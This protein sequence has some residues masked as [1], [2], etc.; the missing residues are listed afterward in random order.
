MGCH[1]SRL[2]S[3][4]VKRMTLWLEHLSTVQKIVDFSTPSLSTDCKGSTIEI[5]VASEVL[6][7][8]SSPAGGP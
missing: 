4:F 7:H 6:G 8:P 3:S 5:K 1:F 2:S